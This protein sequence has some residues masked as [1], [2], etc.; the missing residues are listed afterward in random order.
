ME[1]CRDYGKFIW[2]GNYGQAPFPYQFYPAHGRHLTMFHPCNDGLA[3]CRRAVI[4]NMAAGTLPWE[5]VITHRVEAADS[6][7]VY[8][9]IN[10]GNRDNVLAA[11]IHWS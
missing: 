5:L 2:Q 8:E 11:V 4:K 7:A 1:L 3:P 6:P 9:G 10:G